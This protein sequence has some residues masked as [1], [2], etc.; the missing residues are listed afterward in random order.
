MVPA[1]AVVEVLRSVPWARRARPKSPRWASK[2]T[3]SRTLLGLTSRWT[4][5]PP[6]SSWR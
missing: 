5:V 4:T 1:R 2:S 6:H 3:S